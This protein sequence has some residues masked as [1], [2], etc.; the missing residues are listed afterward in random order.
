MDA[1]FALEKKV[2]LGNLKG[3][4]TCEFTKCYTLNSIKYLVLCYANVTS[5]TRSSHHVGAWSWHLS[6]AKTGVR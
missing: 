4:V 5:K 6:C 1:G 2:P 3:C